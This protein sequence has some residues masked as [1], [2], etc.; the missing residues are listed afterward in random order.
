MGTVRISAT[1]SSPSTKFEIEA[2]VVETDSANNRSKVRVYMKAYNGPSGN[3]TSQ[4]NNSG[5]QRWWSNTEGARWHG[6]VAPFLPSGYAQNQ[7]R[8]SEQTD[9][10]LGHDGNGNAQLQFGM[11]VTYPPNTDADGDD[12]YSGI[13]AAPRIPR[14]PGAPGTPGVSSILPTGATISWGAATRGH[15]DIDQYLLRMHTNPNPDAGG[16]TD[17]PL[18]GGTL[19]RIVTG[20]TPGTRYYCKVYAHNA[21]GYSAGSAVTTFETLAGGRAWDGSAWRNCKVRY[22]NGG[23]WQL[24]RVRTWDGSAWRNTR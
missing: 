5:S 22:W 2:D 14:V 20:L 6:P 18:G 17:Y 16:Y 10:W 19:A 21:D 23:A 7:L 15:A 13:W 9:Y 12:Y 1:R 4:F 11:N 8:W 3:S 24:V